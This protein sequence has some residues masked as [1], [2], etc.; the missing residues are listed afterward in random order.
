M[1]SAALETVA[2]ALSETHSARRGIADRIPELDGI[3]GVAILAVML[4]HYA[5]LTP[6]LPFHSLAYRAQAAFRLGWSG[7]DLFF[8]LSG[9]LI[10]GI[11]IGARNSPRYFQTFYARRVLRIL[12]IS[13]LWLT[14]FRLTA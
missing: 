13:V 9:F 4:Y 14:L 10:G 7:V 1:A 6:G 2:S 11:L 8:V 3:R 12:P 5:S